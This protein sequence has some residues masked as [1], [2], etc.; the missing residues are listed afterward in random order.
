MKSWSKT[1]FF[2]IMLSVMVLSLAGC[3]NRDKPC[4]EKNSNNSEVTTKADHDLHF[5]RR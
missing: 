3:K 1:A 2:I 5:W 4:K